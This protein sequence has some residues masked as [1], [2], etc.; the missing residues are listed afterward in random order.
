[1]NAPK[2]LNAV[3]NLAPDVVVVYGTSLIKRALL[4]VMPK[5]VINLHAGLSPYYRGA[6]TLYW[7]IYFMEPQNL[8]YTFHLIDLK[9]DHGDILHQY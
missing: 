4:S 9:I 8:G 6:A 2:V 1:M 3:K 5:Y 7:P